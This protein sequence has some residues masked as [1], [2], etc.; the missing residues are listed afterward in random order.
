[1]T[2]NIHS[3]KIYTNAG[4]MNK[5]RDSLS[6]L[7]NGKALP[8]EME[9]RNVGCLAGIYQKWYNQENPKYSMENGQS[10]WAFEAYF[11]SFYFKSGK[12]VTQVQKFTSFW[13]VWQWQC[14]VSL[15]CSGYRSIR[16]DSLGSG[17]PHCDTTKLKPP[18][19]ILHQFWLSIERH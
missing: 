3:L 10:M 2:C 13:W 4:A 18:V 9:S 12:S 6:I 17:L 16:P 11:I 8:R 14:Y 1:M 5:L 19:F 15:G 7:L